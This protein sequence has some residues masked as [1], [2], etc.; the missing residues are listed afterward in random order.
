MAQMERMKATGRFPDA[1]LYGSLASR[2][3][4]KDAIRSLD[5][6]QEIKKSLMG[7]ANQVEVF[8]DGMDR[9]EVEI[10]MR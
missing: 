9:V 4:V 1:S 7:I 8:E 2:V 5:K 6:T 10:V 3:M